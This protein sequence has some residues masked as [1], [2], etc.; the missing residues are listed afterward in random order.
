[1]KDL[2]ESFL[3]LQASPFSSQANPDIGRE[4]GI[5]EASACQAEPQAV[6]T[7]EYGI[8]E[9]QEKEIE[10]EVPKPVLSPSEGSPALTAPATPMLEDHFQRTR[11][12]APSE[13]S[14]QW[15]AQSGRTSF[16]DL[17]QGMFN[18]ER[19]VSL[20]LACS[21]SF[22]RYLLAPCTPMY[23]FCRL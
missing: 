8:M 22:N 15:S 19:P 14:F 18:L 4:V 6:N 17:A 7:E 16:A 9:T 5:I 1:M 13:S 10:V 12:P 3:L 21:L 11:S 23:S 20:T 2:I